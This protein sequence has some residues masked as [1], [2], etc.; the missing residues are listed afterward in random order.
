MSPRLL[1]R[2]SDE[3]LGGR[4]A[5]GEAAA[6]DELYRRYSHR[7]AAYGAH[8]LGDQTAGDDVAQATL[9]KAYTALRAGRV[10]ETVRPWLYRVAHNTAI[11]LFAR[12]REYPVADVPEGQSHE[13]TQ[14]GALV[15]ALAGLPESQRRVYVLREGC[16][17]TRPPPSSGSSRRRSSR[18]SSRRGTGWRSCS[19]SAAGSAASRFAVWRPGRST[20]GSAARSR[21]TFARAPTA[22]APS[23]RAAAPSASHRAC[24]SSGCAS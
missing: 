14:A 12:R 17:S 4:L 1:A 9:L 20:G 3:T 24:H 8:L 11:D 19:S 13:G 2:L 23:A 6:F 16:A 22:A 18:P 21:R 7:L 10:P 15:T 5:L